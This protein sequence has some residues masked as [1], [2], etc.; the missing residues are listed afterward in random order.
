MKLGHW[1]K[2]QMLQIHSFIPQ[3]EGGGVETYPIFAL[4]AA[5]SAMQAHFE[6]LLYLDMKQLTK[7]LEVANILSLPTQ[8]AAIEHCHSTI[9]TLILLLSIITKLNRVLASVVLHYHAKFGKATADRSCDILSADP[10]TQEK[11]KYKRRRR[12]IRKHLLMKNLLLQHS[13]VEHLYKDH[14]RDQQNVVL[15]HR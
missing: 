7:A 2:F 9:F 5:F 15:V 13:T 1:Q 8:C 4:L 11:Y 10:V 3:R 6:K 14:H 12:S